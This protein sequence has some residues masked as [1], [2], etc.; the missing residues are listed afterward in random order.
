MP[1]PALGS[2]AQPAEDQAPVFEPGGAELR[3]A[4]AGEEELLQLGLVQV[5]VLREDGEDGDIPWGQLAEQEVAFSLV[6]RSL[7]LRGGFANEVGI[8]ESCEDSPGSE[9]ALGEIG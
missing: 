3:R 2:E 5:A 4:R 8:S 1:L 9:P 6:E 7:G